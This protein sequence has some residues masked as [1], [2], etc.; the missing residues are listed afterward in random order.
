MRYVAVVKE[1]QQLQWGKSI[2]NSSR[3][4]KGEREWKEEEE[5]PGVV[6][7]AAKDRRRGKPPE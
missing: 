3:N 2:S 7:E 6:D 5:E 4:K 1:Q